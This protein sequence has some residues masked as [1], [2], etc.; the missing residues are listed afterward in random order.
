MDYRAINYLDEPPSAAALK[1]LLSRAGLTPQAAIRTNEEAYRKYV[2][3]R[4][5]SDE[6]L[7]QVMAEHPELIQRPIVVRGDKAVLARP[8]ERL[9]EL[10]IESKHQQN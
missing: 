4:S 3:G 10:G 5:L 7:V 1:Q 2:A 9:A 6:Q 8:L